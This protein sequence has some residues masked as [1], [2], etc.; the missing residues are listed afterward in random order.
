MTSNPSKIMKR[1]NLEDAMNV[2]ILNV[3][4]CVIERTFFRKRAK[5]REI[6]LIGQGFVGE[7][8]FKIEPHSCSGEAVAR[9]ITRRQKQCEQKYWSGPV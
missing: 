9:G 4:R 1:Q 7:T 3:C 6:H 8:A 2:I 5:G